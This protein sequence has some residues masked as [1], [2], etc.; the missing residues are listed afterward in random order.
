MPAAKVW[1]WA[2][3]ESDGSLQARSCSIFCAVTPR[4]PI[5]AYV[6][7]LSEVFELYTE[8]ESIW[9]CVSYILIK[10]ILK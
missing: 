4:T 10:L 9:L 2:A 5:S 1:G 6:Y 8:N 7:I 3:R